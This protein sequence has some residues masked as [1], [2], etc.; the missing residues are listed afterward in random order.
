[1]LSPGLDIRTSAVAAV[2]PGDPGAT[3][4]LVT[5]D[6]SYLRMVANED[7]V[8]DSSQPR[9]KAYFAPSATQLHE[10]FDQVAQD[11][12]VRLAQ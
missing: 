2:P 11:L 9:G 4:E 6:M 8:V 7:G 5:P 3:N 1:M 10:V 12:L